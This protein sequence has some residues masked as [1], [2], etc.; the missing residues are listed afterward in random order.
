[1]G[2]T[3]SKNSKK[4]LKNSKMVKI[5]MKNEKYAIYLLKFLLLDEN[6]KE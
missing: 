2:C 5:G 1:M 4:Y 3:N 6:L